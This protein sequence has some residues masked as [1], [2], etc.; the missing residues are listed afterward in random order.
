MTHT[1]P[2]EPGN[3]LQHFAR[4]ELP[5]QHG[6]FTL[7]VYRDA[8]AAEHMLIS[9]GD[10]IATP[11]PLVRVHSECFT[12]EVLGSLKCDCRE[13]LEKAMAAIVEAGAGAIAY[14]RQ[15]GR[16]IGLGNKVRAYA[17]QEKGADTIEANERLGLP[18]DARD[19]GHA[20]EMLRDQGVT[21]V[22]LN[23]NNPQ[24]VTALRAA[25]I[26][27]AA[28]VASPA[29]PNP[30][31]QEYLRTKM[32]RMGHRGLGEDDGLAG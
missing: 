30:H 22:R 17:E 29:D 31:N 16:G 6:V 18:I 25:G 13:Q 3:S 1:P 20:A 26:E 19:F 12:G 9:Y 7:H 15:E 21:R 2:P 27:V 11:T 23:T 32:L 5:T 4:C 24:K 10:L 28:V 14:L 8:E